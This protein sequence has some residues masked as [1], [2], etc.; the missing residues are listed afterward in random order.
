MAFSDEFPHLAA[1]FHGQNNDDLE[2]DDLSKGSGK[3]VWWKCEK[4]D[5]HEWEA[6][7]SNRV[8]GRG[9]PFCAGKRV[10]EGY[11]LAVIHPELAIEWHL[12]KNAPEL[13]SDVVPS[14]KKKVW[15][16]CKTD[17]N[18]E[19]QAAIYSRASGVGC[20]YCS[21]RRITDKNRLASRRPDLAEEWHKTKNGDLSPRDFVVGS[22]KRVWWQC[23]RDEE[24]EWKAPIRNRVRGTGCPKCKGSTSRPELRLL[25]ELMTIYEDAESR[26]KIGGVEADIFLPSLKIAIEYDGSYYHKDREAADADKNSFFASLGISTIRVREKPLKRVSK[27]DVL[28]SADRLKKT[29]LDR[30]LKAIDSISGSD[31]EMSE[32]LEHRHFAADKLFRKFISYLPGPIPEASLALKFPRVAEEWN[33]EKNNPLTPFNFSAFSKKNVWWKCRRDPRHEWRATIS[34]RSYGN[35]CPYCSG[36]VASPE[37]ALAKTHTEIA[38]QWHPEK[39]RDLSPEDV[40]AGSSKSVWWKCP[41]SELHDWAATIFSRTSGSGCPYCAGKK[42]AAD[43]SLQAKYPKI[44]SEWNTQRNRGLTPG[45]VSAQTPRKVWWRCAKDASHEWE[46]AISNRVNGRGCPICSNRKTTNQNSLAS[47]EPDVAAQ[48]D[49]S[50]NENLTPDD[51]TFGSAK[52]VW[53]KCEKGEDHV[54]QTEVRGRVAANGCPFCSGRRACSDNNLEVLFPKLAEE[55]DSDKNGATEPSGVV[56]GSAKKVWW[57]CQKDSE[58]CWKAAVYKRAK[59]EHGCPFCAGKRST[60]L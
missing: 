59:E 40:S 2:P 38:E 60:E 22:A 15:W 17:P 34:D 35:G 41:K 11:N 24:H 45:E 23:P 8:K 37:T 50:R 16:R 36:R 18:H 1:E 9:C 52:K 54:W 39:N 57:R 48:W 3:K 13:P 6:I 44:A 58:H 43:T 29:D 25:T 28:V 42:V 56:P 10:S 4:G 7:V 31:D 26:K 30:L 5:D 27:Y 19:W 51:V 21:N 20:P 14:A 49:Y 32:Y 53:W 46:A 12:D 55:W 47:R 33:D